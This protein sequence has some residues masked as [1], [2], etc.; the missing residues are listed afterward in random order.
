M[1]VAAEGGRKPEIKAVVEVE[2]FE[3]KIR[4]CFGDMG[5]FHVMTRLENGGDVASGDTLHFSSVEA[6]DDDAKGGDFDV[7]VEFE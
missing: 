4:A 6:I 3:H 1:F 7:G 5:D 2:V